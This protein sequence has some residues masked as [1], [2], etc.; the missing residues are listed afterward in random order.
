M[1]LLKSL[2]LALMLILLASPVTALATPLASPTSYS[3]SSVT[4]YS[5]ALESNDQLYIVQFSVI[6]GSLPPTDASQAWI[7]RL[8]NGATE[9]AT[10]APYAFYNSGYATG[11]VSFYLPA[12]LAPAWGGA[13]TVI[14]EPN[15]TL[16]WVSLP[17]QSIFNVIV[18]S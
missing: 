8:M 15:P 17:P 16:S 2:F 13:Y 9:L 10:A 14:L 11:V 18:W 3:I 7:I 4:V 1:K 6:Y 12:A 5:P